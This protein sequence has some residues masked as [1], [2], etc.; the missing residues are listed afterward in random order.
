MSGSGIS[1]DGAVLGWGNNEVLR[2]VNVEIHSGEFVLVLGGSGA[3]KSTM[4]AAMAGMDCVLGGSVG[5]TGSSKAGFVPQAT[6]EMDTPFSIEEYVAL[7]SVRGGWFVSK[8]ERRAAV[9]VL[10]SL[11]LGDKI[12]ERL[13]NL[14]GGQRQRVLIARAMAASPSLLLCDEPTSGADTVTA[15]SV[16]DLLAGIS[17]GG[18]TIVVATHDYRAFQ[19]V[20]DRVVGVHKNAV[21]F[22]LTG[23][24]FDEQLILE[25]YGGN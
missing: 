14:S 9:Q 19:H 3:G 16:A 7:G 2:G 15:R 11:G 10:E 25:L 6:S 12:G 21:R 4:L 1:F 20:A 24:N 17:N 8:T 23:G 13:G 22:D 18:R 5:F